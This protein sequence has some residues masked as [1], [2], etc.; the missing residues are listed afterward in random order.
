MLIK[1]LATEIKMLHAER[2]MYVK[3]P[4]GAQWEG[5]PVYGWNEKS[6]L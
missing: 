4:K 2:E 3:S 6:Y 1:S 5:N